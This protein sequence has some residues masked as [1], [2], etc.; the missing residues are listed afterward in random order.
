MRDEYKDRLCE[1]MRAIALY[2]FC[3][4]EVKDLHMPAKDYYG[5][6]MGMPGSTMNYGSSSSPFYFYSSRRA[7]LLEAFNRSFSLDFEHAEDQD[8]LQPL[9]YDQDRNGIVY[10]FVRS[11]AFRDVL[12]MES[13]LKRGKPDGDSEFEIR[14]AS[15][16][17]IDFHAFAIQPGQ[18]GN[19]QTHSK[20]YRRR[21]RVL[22]ER[23]RRCRLPVF[24][25][26]RLYESIYSLHGIYARLQR[27]KRHRDF[28]R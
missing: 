8:R 22:L 27:S 11:L 1:E 18:G 10:N 21:K 9:V 16:S 5:C 23:G 26:S 17:G 28:R 25:G 2:M 24:D 12:F 19:S 20:Q 14:A 13:G 15:T 3:E 7:R 4:F 6:L